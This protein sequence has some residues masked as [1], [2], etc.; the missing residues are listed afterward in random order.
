MTIYYKYMYS[1]FLAVGPLIILIVLNSFIILVTVYQSK[2]RKVIELRCAQG[3]YDKNSI[4]YHNSNQK[5]HVEQSK[6][7]LISNS[8][9]TNNANDNAQTQLINVENVPTNLT[10]TAIPIVESSGSSSEDNI[11]LVSLSNIFF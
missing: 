7:K 4:P 2:R 9:Y 10:T 6:S 3:H 8:E 11:A 5:I 1:I